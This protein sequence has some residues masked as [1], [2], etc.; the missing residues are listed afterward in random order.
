MFEL[1]FVSCFADNIVV[2]FIAKFGCVNIFLRNFMHE[3]E[4]MS[5]TVLITGMAGFIGAFFDEEGF[6]ND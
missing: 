2:E 4:K 6:G 3:R 5:K 1:I